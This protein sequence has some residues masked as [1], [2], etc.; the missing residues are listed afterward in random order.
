MTVYSGWVWYQ[1]PQACQWMRDIVCVLRDGGSG[2]GKCQGLAVGAGI[3]CGAAAVV[4]VCAEGY[5][6]GFCEC[7]EHAV[8]VASMLWCSGDHDRVFKQDVGARSPSKGS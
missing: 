1:S 2:F 4:A 6:V 5:W 3:Q 7:R 8:G